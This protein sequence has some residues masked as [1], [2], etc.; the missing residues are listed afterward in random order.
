VEEAGAVAFLDR[1]GLPEA[2]ARQYQRKLA[3]GG[4]LIAVQVA[5]LKTAAVAR[6]ILEEAHCQQISEV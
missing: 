2:V 3:E 1:F 6:K 5:K 4:I